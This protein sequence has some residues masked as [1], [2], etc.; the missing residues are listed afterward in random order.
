MDDNANIRSTESSNGNTDQYC[1]KENLWPTQNI[2]HKIPS[3]TDSTICVVAPWFEHAVANVMT[4]LR[5]M[6]DGLNYTN[7]FVF[8]LANETFYPKD[9]ERKLLYEADD[10]SV[11]WHHISDMVR[12]CIW[13][14]YFFDQDTIDR[15]KSIEQRVPLWYLWR[16]GWIVPEYNII[17]GKF[18][19]SSVCGDILR[20]KKNYDKQDD[21]LHVMYTFTQR[22]T[23][24]E[25]MIREAFHVVASTHYGKDAILSIDEVGLQI[26]PSRPWEAVSSD[27]IV[28]I[29]DTKSLLYIESGLEMK[30]RGI[31]ES[32]PYGHSI[33]HEYFDQIMHT[34]YTLDLPDYWFACQ[35]KHLTQ[36]SY[37]TYNNDYWSR[38]MKKLD[39]W[40][41]GHYWPT[42]W[43]GVIG[44]FRPDYSNADAESNSDKDKISSLRKMTIENRINTESVFEHCISFGKLFVK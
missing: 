32:L 5:N 12:D 16:T 36:V 27:G 14:S 29:F 13:K 8:K 26:S 24:S 1:T 33:P 35:S 30:C 38:Q 4:S 6:V 28:R 2:I 19:S 40:Y 22:G 3:L 15:V 41:W 7:L 39:D 18:I 43:L 34:M 11:Y 17:R 23:A 10:E 20:H 9:Q 44:A 21:S 42:L 37:Y 25:P 31:P